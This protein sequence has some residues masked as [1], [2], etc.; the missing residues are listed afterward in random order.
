MKWLFVAKLRKIRTMSQLEKIEAVDHLEQTLY[1]KEKEAAEKGKDKLDILME[2][3]AE[4]KQEIEQLSQQKTELEYNL[5][6]V[7]KENEYLQEQIVEVQHE[8]EHQKEIATDKDQDISRYR[9]EYLNYKASYDE[10]Q[11][12]VGAL[13]GKVFS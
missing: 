8:N 11:Q 4:A 7:R 6:Q 13:E 10:S 2:E 5:I 9:D 3:L 12:Y 1:D